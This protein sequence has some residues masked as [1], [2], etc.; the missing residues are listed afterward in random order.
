MKPKNCE[1]PVFLDFTSL[2]VRCMT[3]SPIPLKQDLCVCYYA[4]EAGGGKQHLRNPVKGI[5]LCLSS[6]KVIQCTWLSHVFPLSFRPTK[7]KA[8]PE[9]NTF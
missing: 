2:F 3:D 1:V 9:S 5:S 6:I 8:L 4:P 7:Q